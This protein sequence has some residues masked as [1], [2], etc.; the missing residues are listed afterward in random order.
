[1]LPQ[2]CNPLGIGET[3]LSDPYYGQLEKPCIELFDCAEGET[4]FFNKKIIA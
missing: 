3:T 4:M 2:R 1:M